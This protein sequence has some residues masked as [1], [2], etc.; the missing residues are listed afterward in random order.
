MKTKRKISAYIL[1]GS[2]A[3]LLFSCV[4]VALCSAINL[5]E[6]PP[7]APAPQDNAGFGANGHQS[8][9]LSFADRVAYQSAI[10]EVYWRHRIWP[11]ANAGPK[12]SLDAVMSQA[13]IEK[14]VEDYLRNSQALEDYW[15][16]PLT[17]DQLQTE[18]E[19][20]VSHTKQPEVL[21]ELF[22]AL[23][24]DPFVIAECLARSVLTER[25]IADLSAQ[26]QTG[27][28]ES[29]R[30]AELRTVSTAAMLGQVAYTLPVIANPSG[31]CTDDTWTPTTLTTA[32]TARH[33]HT[34][35]WTGSEMIV[36]GGG[37]NPGVYFNSGRRYNPST[38]SWTATSTT[39][40]PSARNNHKA[41]WTGSEMIVWGGTDDHSFFNTGGRY[42]PGTD[43]WTATST[44]NAPAGRTQH[45][46]VWANTEMIVWGGPISNNDVTNTGGRYNPITDSWITTSTTNAPEARQL[47]TAV[48]TDSEMIVWGGLAGGALNT[49]GRYNPSTDSWTA[50]STTNAPEARYLHTAVWTESE[51]IVWGG[52][53]LGGSNTGGRYNPST[54]SWTATSTT[55]APEGRTQHTAVWTGSEMIVWGGNPDFFNSTGT[56]GRYNPVSGTW[57]ATST[58]GAPAGRV[59]HTAVWT[60][61]EMIV[62][63]GNT[64]TPADLNTGG[65]YCA[66]AAV[67]FTLSAAKRK[68]GGINTVRLTWSGATSNNIDVYRDGMPIV[69]TAN[70]GSYVDS[71]GD[72][73]RARYTYR[74]CEAGSDTCSNDARVGFRQ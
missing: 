60:G 39:N 70:D 4:I 67:P 59:A 64:E 7:K 69:R 6:Q 2:T 5:P 30:T 28:L 29:P 63:G 23:G 48:W 72:T 53:A 31:G 11:N 13:E 18:M 73:G 1:R 16:R 58:T 44:T 34:A 51:M 55:N 20:M 12:P 25:L 27:R 50:T 68:V 54:D 22:E 15:Q 56:G 17:A 41:V 24:N 61:S 10:E 42:N 38:D 49:G 57:T 62:W 45:T 65:R 8:R 43:S 36:W 47:H 21:R 66:A 37:G 32:P 40:A 74:V 14:K 71:T 3:A 9:S 33:A 35:V 52:Y 46:A 19:R 26:H